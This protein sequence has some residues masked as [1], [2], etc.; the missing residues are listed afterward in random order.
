MQTNKTRAENSI[1]LRKCEGLLCLS[2]AQVLK[3]LNGIW[4]TNIRRYT[5]NVDN[6]I[7]KKGAIFLQKKKQFQI[8]PRTTKLQSIHICQPKRF[9]DTFIFL[10]F[11]KKRPSLTKFK[12]ILCYSAESFS[13]PT[14]LLLASTHYFTE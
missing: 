4:L 5:R 11:K 9:S 10:I 13:I 1:K 6:C 8:V 14:F 7:L 2:C 3:K 12:L